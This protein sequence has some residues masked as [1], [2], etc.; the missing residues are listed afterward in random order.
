MARPKNASHNSLAGV[1][2]NLW[3]IRGNH[4]SQP[5]TITTIFRKD[6]IVSGRGFYQIGQ[7]HLQAQE[8]TEFFQSEHTGGEPHF[9]QSWPKSVFRSTVGLSASGGR[10]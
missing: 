7:T 2:R 5:R 10:T 4:F 8:I 6:G 1:L 9:M 3:T